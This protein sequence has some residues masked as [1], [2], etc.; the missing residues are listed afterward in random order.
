MK[1]LH[2]LEQRKH[3]QMK[4]N[5]HTCQEIG[6]DQGRC[7]TFSSLNPVCRHRYDT[8]DQYFRY[9]SQEHGMKDCR[10]EIGLC[11]QILKVLCIK[12]GR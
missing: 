5:H 1:N 2:L 4:R 11:K 7:L 10:S 6:V 3:V 12:G 8:Y 9:H